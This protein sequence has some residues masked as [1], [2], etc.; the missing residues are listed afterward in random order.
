MRGMS[1]LDEMRLL[2]DLLRCDE[3]PFWRRLRALLKLRGYDPQKLVVM[4][5]FEDDDHK[6]FGVL[7]TPEKE[8]F[9]Y[10]FVYRY[11]N[12]SQGVITSWRKMT[13]KYSRGAYR[14]DY[15]AALQLLTA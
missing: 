2:T 1:T 5:S 14:G 9:A 10:D 7:V 15:S 11:R 12:I 6:E 3:N 4:Y 8:V 13:D